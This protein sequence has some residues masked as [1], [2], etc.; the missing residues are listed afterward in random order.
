M[1]VSIVRDSFQAPLKYT[2]MFRAIGFGITLVIIK[3]MMPDVFSGLE[4]TLVKL[5]AVLQDSLGHLPTLDTQ[6]AQVFPHALM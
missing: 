5:F 2:N 4:V 1:A 6:S 3:V